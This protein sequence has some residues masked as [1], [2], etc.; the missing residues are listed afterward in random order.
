MIVLQDLIP[1]YLQTFFIFK[2][3]TFTLYT[4][5]TFLISVECQFFTVILE[6]KIGKSKW[7]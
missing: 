3:L 7:Y 2:I 5:G 4:S 1:K 6:I